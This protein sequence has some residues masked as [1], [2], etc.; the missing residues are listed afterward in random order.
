MN[1][2]RPIVTAAEMRACEAQAMSTGLSGEQ[3]MELAGTAIAEA[4]ARFGGGR[5]TLILCGPGNNGG[6]G[7]VA[8]RQLAERGISVRIAA[9]AESKTKAAK[10]ARARWTGSIEAIGEAKPA[11]V[12]VDALFGTGVT[13]PLAAS[14]NKLL[15]NL[16][17]QSDFV[18]AADMPSGVNCDTGALMGAIRA[19]LTIALGGLKPAHLL[20]PAAELCGTVRIA[21]IGIAL[22]STVRS[23]MPPRLTPPSVASHKYVRGM[24]AI[25][26]GE[27]PGA[28]RLAAESAMRIAGY[29]VLTGQD[30]IGSAA[31]V[32]R[33]WLSIASDAHIGALLIG[34]GLGRGAEAQIALERALGSVH[35]LVLD[36]D[37]LTLLAQTPLPNFTRRATP[38]ILT[39]HA[40]E[41]DRLFGT[42]GGSKI[43]RARAASATCGATII[44]K[45]ADTIVAAP[46]GRIVVSLR[47]SPW[48]ASAGTGDVLAGIVT[49]LLS[50]R[51]APFASA[52]AAVWLHSE[53]ARLAGPSLIADELARFIP[54]AVATCL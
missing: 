42:G 26:G 20:Q 6:D 12:I 48:L 1:F 51:L 36:G 14:L 4:V 29:V 23:I 18:V 32:H 21:D 41:F 39:P 43:D 46:D 7:Y 16:A 34:P 27:M 9:T 54:A 2:G 53:A 17:A 37:A 33:D 3:L 15:T 35:P 30:R 45:G 49:A 5:D 28:A 13:R 22:S 10:A 24:V 19:D 52:E 25:V 8:G 31:L 11:S 50:T 38:V 47:G 40:A 44:L